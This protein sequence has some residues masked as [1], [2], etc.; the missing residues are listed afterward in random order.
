MEDMAAV[1]RSESQA[2]WEV[3]A[4]PARI[5]IMM[6]PGPAGPLALPAESALGQAAGSEAAAAP[7][8]RLRHY[9]RYCVVD[10]QHR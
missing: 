2:D 6:Q 5:M 7:A 10:V 8:A 3:R 9:R 1:G 4:L